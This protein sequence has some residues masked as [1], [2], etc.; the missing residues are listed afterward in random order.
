[1][2][3]NDSTF[4]HEQLVSLCIDFFMAGSDTTTN[5]LTF[6]MFFMMKHEDI[7]KKVQTELDEVVGRNRWPSLEDRLK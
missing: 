4:T 3:I 1:M 5:T 6:S 2:N 7:Q